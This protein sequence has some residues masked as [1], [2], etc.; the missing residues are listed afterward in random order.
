MF[1]AW[2]LGCLVELDADYVEELET[3]W[4]PIPHNTPNSM[5]FLCVLK[6]FKRRFWRTPR[7]SGADF[8]G[9]GVFLG[10]VV[11]EGNSYIERHGTLA[12]K[13]LVRTS[14]ERNVA[15]GPM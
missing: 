7:N 13:N 9:L 3:L 4:T 10:L 5:G 8:V 14:L 6:I 15:K 1:R 2:G 12:K 11:G